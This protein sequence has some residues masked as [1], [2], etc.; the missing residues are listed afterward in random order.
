MASSGKYAGMYIGDPDIDFVELAGSQNVAGERVT[1]GS[2][3]RAALERGIN[4]TK[5]GNP[6]LVEVVVARYGGGAD[7]TWHESFNLASHRKM[8]I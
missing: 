6:Y 5:E 7:S 2:D 1:A 3:L 4:A 8:Q